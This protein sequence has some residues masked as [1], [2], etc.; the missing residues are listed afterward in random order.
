MGDDHL[1][2]PEILY[3]MVMKESKR[4]Q[5]SP[6]RWVCNGEAFV[7]DGSI[8]PQVNNILKKYFNRKFFV[9]LITYN[10]DG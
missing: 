4:G 10:V 5:S 6:I 1:P 7:V 2:F 3:N 9:V 8:Q